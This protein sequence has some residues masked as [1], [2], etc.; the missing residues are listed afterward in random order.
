MKDEALGA[1]EAAG[2]M[3]LHWS[4][5]AKM[6]LQGILSSRVVGVSGERS[7]AVYSRNE[8]EQ[9]YADYIDGKAIRKRPRTALDERPAIL[10][11]LAPKSRPRI[12]YGDAI[13]LAEA[14]RILGVWWTL[15]PR[16]VRDG[17]LVGRIL[18]SGRKN[19]SR[20]WIISRE[21]CEQHRA[22]VAR[23][24]QAGTKRGRPRKCVDL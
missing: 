7:F 15:V 19:S 12:A 5:P 16:L 24:E 8:C 21:S 17:K 2:L 11:A 9:N 4:R 20:L 18:H 6:V 13:S 22:D 14:G 10:R 23:Q 1:W 3:G